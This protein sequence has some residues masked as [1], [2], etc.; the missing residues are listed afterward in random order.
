MGAAGALTLLGVS[1][2]PLLLM[3]WE[4]MNSSRDRDARRDSKASV[5]AG[6]F[7]ALISRREGAA[8]KELAGLCIQGVAA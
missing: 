6:C 4:S 8:R 7:F 3:S 1:A 5:H 2:S